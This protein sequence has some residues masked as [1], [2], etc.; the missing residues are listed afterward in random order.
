[1]QANCHS[2][3]EPALIS[4]QYAAEVEGLLGV[5][6]YQ[7]DLRE[8]GLRN[9]TLLFSAETAGMRG[10]LYVRALRVLAHASREHD[11]ELDSPN[12]ARQ[13]GAIAV[14]RSAEVDPIARQLAII[15]V[16]EGT[17]ANQEESF[18]GGLRPHQHPYLHD[19]VGFMNMA[20]RKVKMRGSD[21][22]F[23]RYLRGAFVEAPTGL[24]KTVLIA[25]TTVA[26]GVGQPLENM[27]RPQGR[28]RALIIVPS[29]TLVEQMTGKVGD[30]TLRNFAPGIEISGYYQHEK[31][32]QAD[33][34]V[35]TIDQF[36]AH[37]RD[38]KLNGQRFDVCIVDECH[39]LTEPLLEKTIAEHWQGEPIIGFT[40][41]PITGRGRNVGDILTHRI[42]HGDMLDY[43]KNTDDVLNAAQLYEILV[44]H[45]AYLAG[46]LRKAT[47]NMS[48]AEIDQLVLRE[49]TADYLASQ[50]AEGRRGIL[51]CEQGGGEASGYALKLAER[52]RQLTRPDGTPLQVAVAGT[53]NK[54]R[55]LSDPLN[56][57]NIRKR[58]A[59]GELDFIVTVSWG[60]EGLNEDIDSVTVI[61][62]VSS[63]PKFLQE[64]GR[65]TRLS[66]RF[67]I[68]IYGHLFASI[69]NP[70]AQSL[71]GLLGFEEIEQ[72]KII[73]RKDEDS[74]PTPL[75]DGETIKIRNAQNR[76]AKAEGIPLSAFPERLQAL[77]N[78]IDSKTVGEALLHPDVRQSVPKGYMPFESIVENVPG[79]H[80]MIKRHLRHEKEFAWVGRYEEDHRFVFYFEPAAAEYLK[81]Y[82]NAVA[83]VTL[84]REFGGVDVEVVNA[85]AEECLVTSVDW[86]HSSGKFISHYLAADA[87]KIR[88]KFAEVP[89]ALPTDYSRTRIR[90]ELGFSKKISIFERLTPQEIMKSQPKRTTIADGKIRV[91]EHWSQEDGEAIVKRLK[92]IQEAGGAPPQLA[93]VSQA[94]R[95]VETSRAGIKRYAEK[96][97]MPSEITQIAHAGSRPRCIR[98]KVVEQALNHFGARSVVD[99]TVDFSRLPQ[100]LEDDDPEKLAYARTIIAKLES[101]PPRG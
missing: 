2:E 72:G 43:M 92:A 6:T 85:I 13:L 60:R 11:L 66:K 93:T 95:M 71:F 87:E 89:H 96:I 39:H 34:V 77:I 28:V 51:F 46:E 8:Q 91:L 17:L 50:V 32:D 75:L 99:F 73:G 78:S 29:Q 100:S 25:R 37:F 5:R 20:P 76:R 68:T 83:R 33:A 59:A 14:E 41:T 18:L 42:F 74:T 12:I 4:P 30:D 10:L 7:D 3:R 15:N 57:V 27:E 63:P 65:G 67:P 90:D 16:A 55:P 38:G 40:A 94:A 61:G 21:G 86:F 70:H 48:K 19:L 69:H 56:N 36:V 84:Q 88:K 97:G 24:G 52:L 22:P 9:R 53:L 23:E 35:I 26:L 49:A 54:N 80:T 81:P 79:T 62:T 47:K 64:I 101:L 98:W 44:T 31:N 58:Y 45:D 82:I 1:M